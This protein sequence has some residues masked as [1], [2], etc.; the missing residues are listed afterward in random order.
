MTT[1]NIN[2]V[3][4]MTDEEDRFTTF[5]IDKELISIIYKNVYR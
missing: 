4:I 2:K 1:G 5:I 3:K